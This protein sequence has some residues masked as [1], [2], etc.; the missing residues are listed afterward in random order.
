MPAQGFVDAPP[1]QAKFVVASHAMANEENIRT[2]DAWTLPWTATILQLV[3]M[4]MTV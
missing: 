4:V 1:W 3:M 2:Q